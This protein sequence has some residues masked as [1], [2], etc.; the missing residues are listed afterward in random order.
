MLFNGKLSIWNWEKFSVFCKE[1]KKDINESAGYQFL[2]FTTVF[3]IFFWNL[4]CALIFMARW[5]LILRLRNLLTW[6]KK[7][8][9]SSKSNHVVFM[10]ILWFFSRKKIIKIIQ[11]LNHWGVQKMAK[12]EESCNYPKLWTSQPCF[13]TAQKEVQISKNCWK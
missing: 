10:L 6:K 7:K 4:G 1:K 5:L 9:M 3:V 8:K 2:K 11:Y 13:Y 12:R